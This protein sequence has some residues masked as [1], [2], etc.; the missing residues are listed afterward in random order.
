MQQ[1]IIRITSQ[2]IK[3]KLSLKNGINLLLF[4]SLASHKP[5]FC[6]MRHYK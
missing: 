4:G 6:E 3:K 5:I 2:E 1:I